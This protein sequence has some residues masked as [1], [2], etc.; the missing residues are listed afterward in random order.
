MNAIVN[1]KLCGRWELKVPWFLGLEIIGYVIITNR[2]NKDE[3]EDT[4]SEEI[5][6]DSYDIKPVLAPLFPPLSQL[7]M[8]FRFEEPCFYGLS[9]IES[10]EDFSLPYD[11]MKFV[12]LRSKGILVF[13]FIIFYSKI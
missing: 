2:G 12:E 13:N 4:P 10:E 5:K 8:D 7:K 3:R 11:L 6:Q 1:S 9:L